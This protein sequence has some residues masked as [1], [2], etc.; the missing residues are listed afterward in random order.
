MK[1]ISTIVSLVLLA[2]TSEC[3]AQ[4]SFTED[5]EDLTTTQSGR[6]GPTQLINRG[7]AF[8][9]LSDPIGTGDWR[10]SPVAYQGSWS[11][12]VDWS[13]GWWNDSQS[14]MS[15]W[16]VLPAIPNQITGDVIR[17]FTSSGSADSFDPT[18]HIEIRYS[19]DG[20]T[21]TGSDA[22]RVGD[23]TELL[24]DIPDLEIF[25]FTEHLA[26]L[27]GNGRIALR[28]HIP[29]NNNGFPTF[30]GDFDIDTLSVGPN[31]PTCN[32]PP[33]P[34]PGQTVTWRLADSPYTVCER[35][36]IPVGGTVIIE[37]GVVVNV[38]Q[39]IEI[40]VSGTIEAQGTSAQHIVIDAPAVFP[41]A[42][43][44]NLGTINAS[45]VDFGGQLRTETGAELDLVDCN[46]AGFG[47]LLS[48][49]L[50]DIRPWIELT[51]CTFTDS[52]MV[53]SDSFG[54]LTDNT[55]LNTDINILR[56]YF[57]FLSINTVVGK[58]MVVNG[59]RMPQAMPIDG[60]HASGV[61]NGA[62]LEV[63]GGNYLIGP[64]NVLLNNR[65]ALRINGGI[66]R[67]SVIPLTGNTINA[68]DA[69]NGSTPAHGRWPNF[70]IPYR[71]TE[72]TPLGGG[73]L[74]ID[75]GVTVEAELPLAGLRLGGGQGP[76]IMGL[77]NA[78]ITFKPAIPGHTWQGLI[79][80]GSFISGQH[81]EYVHISDAFAGIISQNDFIYVSNSVI[82]NN[83]IGSNTNN[84]GITY[85]DGTRFIN[86]DTGIDLT[87]TGH[88]E[89]NSPN[90]PN[91]FEG[92]SIG[93]F[94]ESSGNDAR[95]TWWNHSTGPQAFTNPDGLGD[96]VSGGV[97][98]QPYLTTPPDFTVNPPVVRLLNPGFH[99]GNNAGQIEFVLNDAEKYIVQ[100]DAIGDNIDHF[101]IEYSPNGHIPPSNFI[102]IADNIAPNLRSF[103][104]TIPGPSSAREQFVR[105][106]GVDSA[107]R[108]GFDQSR[109][110]LPSQSILNGEL[111]I[112][113]NLTGQ[114]FFASDDFPNMH[115]TGSV[116]N[117]PTI[118]PLV[119][120]ENEGNAISGL[121][122]SGSGHFFQPIPNISTDRARLAL[123]VTN[124]GNNVRF[125]YADG[126]FSIRHDPR[127]GF[128]PAEVT[129]LTP[130]DTQSFSGGS[131]IPITWTASAEEGLHSFDI[132]A[133]YNA[134]RTWH[135]IVKELPPEAR[136]FDWRLPPSEGIADVR[137]RVVV[138]DRRFQNSADGDDRVISIAPGA[139]CQA[140]LNGD[141][142]LNF[143][144]VSAFLSAFT[145]G[146]PAA[147]FTGDGELN[148]FDVSAFLN[149]FTAGCP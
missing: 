130:M 116:S 63:L 61:S 111:T 145:A 85:F 119:L 4:A 147:D 31:G 75:P 7:W 100:W 129:M 67:Q 17:F 107:G 52:L 54:I 135:P 36:T 51:R 103:E 39:G 117:L 48:Q 2:S 131:I 47:L 123:Q 71:L 53:I 79:F 20:G 5:F 109:I 28:F 41:P 59:Q 56:G 38:E 58:P 50:Q 25:A 8:T 12:H 9:N 35:L 68:I 18:A 74:T 120:L 37:P 126:Y 57:D 137:L 80:N 69:G 22:D 55:F 143:F 105:I 139:D 87:P 13:V 84:F 113:T 144:D 133:S 66:D 114:T 82:E 29:P 146:D 23:F 124:N 95:N 78:P 138:H 72:D 16:A 19:P 122:V 70:G 3:L 110:I 127:F 91:S 93:I 76:I 92:N 148:F 11:L 142:E 88:A 77:P 10:R 132:L 98:F 44:V 136:S 24:L 32:Q 97:I 81:L 101:R 15:S 62:G 26:I 128:V 140:D 90:N 34:S 99:W 45:F 106:V 102:I 125:F 30:S 14:E 21:D 104:W 121:T 49:E 27:P 89:L 115:W 1:L 83:Q 60:V 149:A 141:G 43:R 46:F 118:T 108:E 96:S 40:I 112:T 33:V 6:H 86:N 134:G 73:F 94:S 42:L 64:N 65:Y